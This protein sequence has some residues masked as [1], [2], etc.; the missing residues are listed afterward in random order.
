MPSGF[1]TNALYWCAEAPLQPD[2]PSLLFIHASWMSS[3]MWEET[4]HSLSPQLPDINLVR[5]DLNGHGKTTQGRT[6]Y[7]LW[8]QAQDV[9]TVLT[10]LNLSKVI[11]VAISM[12]AM[13]ALRMALLHQDQLSGLI[14]LSANAD[15]ASD[16]HRIGFPDVCD[17]W[18]STPSPSNAIMNSAILAWGGSPDLRGPRAQRIRQDWVERHSGA[19]NIRPTLRSMM[20]RDGLLHRLGEIWVPVLLVHGEDDQT[21]PV[22]DA[23]DIHNALVNAEAR[24][25]IIPGEGHLLVCL[26]DSADVTGLIKGFVEKAFPSM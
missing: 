22:Q 24:L 19:E 1:A 12:G 15:K 13:V 2:R 11:V 9:L 14:L 23:L 25:E 26:R 4:V 10:E 21:Y 5:V 16:L 6:E 7:T 18:T 8:D 20:E 3:S 17:T